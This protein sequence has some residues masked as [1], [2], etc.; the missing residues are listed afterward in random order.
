MS[1]G[2]LDCD[3]APEVLIEF[4]HSPLVPPRSGHH[5][6]QVFAELWRDLMAKEPNGW[7]ESRA[8]YMLAVVLRWRDEEV[9]QRAA[10]VAATFIKWLGVNCGACFLDSCAKTSAEHPGSDRGYVMAWA[11][12]NQRKSWLNGG[13]RTIEHILA[14]D[15][16]RRDAQLIQ[17]PDL[18]ADD[19]EVVEAVVCW[20]SEPAGIEFVA[21]C[22]AELAQRNMAEQVAEAVANKDYRRLKFILREIGEPC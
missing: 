13:F 12:E 4:E 18:T 16:L 17:R 22:K 7:V 2:E 6:E 3:E 15:D 10:S 5:G 14:T 11:Y 1:T 19:Y 8:N 21:K 9:T 20:L